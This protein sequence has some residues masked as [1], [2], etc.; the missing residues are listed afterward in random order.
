MTGM[1]SILFSRFRRRRWRLAAA[2]LPILVALVWLAIRF[3]FPPEKFQRRSGDLNVILITID[4]LRADHVSAFGGKRAST[5]VLDAL[6]AEG[7]RFDHCVSQVPLTLPSH[8]SILSATYP[9]YHQVRDNG[10]FL[11]PEALTLVS[12]VLQARGLDTA[13]FI[14]AFVLHSKW[15]LNQGFSTYSDR[16]DMGRYGKIMLQN[17]KRAGEVLGDARRWFTRHPVQKRFFAW[18]HL[19]SAFPVQPPAAVRCAFSR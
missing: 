10:A 8:V 16:F 15:G 2:A 5:P 14:G 17:E 4:T 11:A 1:S 9:L 7:A 18:I 6:A 12:E 19:R 3:W 13:A